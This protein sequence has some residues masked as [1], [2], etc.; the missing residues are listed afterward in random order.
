MCE[1][2]LIYKYL[3]FCDGS[4]KVLTDG[5]IKFT[6]PCNF[7]DPFD[8]SPDYKTNDIQKY[9]DSHPDWV[10]RY[11]HEQKWSPAELNR[12]K[13]AMTSR[14]KTML[15]NGYG[16]NFSNRVG[17][18][19]L[20]RDPLNLLMWAHYSKHHTGFVVEFS[21]PQESSS[22][23]KNEVQYMEWLVPHKVH[24]QSPK[25][26]V[27]LFDGEMTKAEKQFLIKGKN[28]EYEH[29]ER[30]IDYI[31][32]SGIHIY[33]Q[34]HILYSVIAGM[35]IENTDYTK[36]GNIVADINKERGLRIGFHR[37]APVDGKF[38]LY[39]PGRPDLLPLNH[40]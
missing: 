37:V 14:I 25:P 40:P 18:C 34:K 21:I 22:P 26:F 39:V 31:R 11:A 35:E 36:L 28:W 27:S 33:D 9:L 6:K 20:T 29:E 2:L 7:N 32:G 3:P 16:R 30:V 1:K 4:L 15:K 17:I 38:A 23:I 5:K 10:K 12:K 8:C 13:P 19:S 24:Y